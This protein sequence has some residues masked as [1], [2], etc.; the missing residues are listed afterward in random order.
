MI[1]SP[2]NYNKQTTCVCVFRQVLTPFQL[3]E[4]GDDELVLLFVIRRFYVRV[5]Q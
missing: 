5:V 1:A 3:A 2:G 4:E